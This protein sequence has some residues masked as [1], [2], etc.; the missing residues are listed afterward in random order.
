MNYTYI[1][2]FLVVIILLLIVMKY[3][4]NKN[5]EL[6]SIESDR[7]S[8]IEKLNSQSSLNEEKQVKMEEVKDGSDYVKNSES[9]T[10]MLKALENVEQL[11]WDMEKR[12]DA[13]DKDKLIT[14]Q[15][16]KISDLEEQDRQ[17]AELKNLFT[18]LKSEKM[19]KENIAN[20]CKND[21]QI[22]INDD[23]NLVK[24]LAK[25]DI[26][27]DETIKLDL[28]LSKFIGK[29][30]PDKQP[31]NQNGKCPSM[32][33]R[34]YIHSDVLKGKCHS[35]DVEKLKKNVDFLKKDF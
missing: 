33:R 18:Y 7:K 12:Q 1:N 25:K 32:N 4:V 16:S 27:K 10:D 35:C 31:I 34:R 2:I 20:K 24:K 22:L 19:K 26:L 15:N 11:C 30:Y 23:Y 28:D 13:K 9:M 8:V 3:L 5:F 6:F 17:I 14:L 29:T 21:R